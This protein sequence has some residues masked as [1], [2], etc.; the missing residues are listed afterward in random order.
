VSSILRIV[1][2]LNFVFKRHTIDN[3]H[4]FEMY[5]NCKIIECNKVINN[6]ICYHKIHQQ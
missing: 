5:I 6:K 4:N 3:S 2:S 1:D